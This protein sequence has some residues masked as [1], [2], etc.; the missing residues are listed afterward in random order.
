MSGTRSPQS[1][2]TR[3][4]FL[5]TTG[6]TGMLGVAGAAGM[7]TS[8]GWLAPSQ[9]HAEPEERVARTYHQ[10]HCG[11]H[12]SLACTVRDGRLCLIEPNDAWE[13]KMYATVCLKG[14][15]EVQHVYSN[16]RI[17]TPL[18]L[19]G[20]RGSGDYESISWDE[21]LDLM[22]DTI[23]GIQNKH[24]KDALYISLSAEAWPG[25]GLLPSLFGA[26]L[27]GFEGI[28]IGIGN[29]F[30]P[31]IGGYGTGL[32]YSANDPRDWVNSKTIILMGTNFLESCLVQ[33]TLLFDAKEAG[34]YIVSVDPNFTTTASKSHQWMPIEP[35][36]D[37]ALLL[38]MA[39]AAIENDWLDSDFMAHHTSFPFLVDVETGALL[40]EDTVLEDEAVTGE[41]GEA[42]VQSTFFV[43]DAQT[44]TPQSHD[45]FQ[46]KPAIEGTF[47]IEGRTYTTVF[48]LLKEN[49]KQYTT[50]WASEKTGIPEDDLIELARR[51]AND[52]PASLALGFGGGD[53]YANADVIGHAAAVL[54][55]LT[56]QYGKIGASTGMFGDGGLRFDT[57][58]ALASWEL[59][60]ELA[61]SEDEMSAYDYRYQENNVKAAIFAGDTMQQHFAN[62]QATLDWLDTL[63]FIVAI[64]IYHTTVTSYADLVLPVCTKFESDEEIASVKSCYNHVLLRERVLDPLFESKTDFA[65]QNAIAEKLGYAK[66][67]PSSAEELVRFSIEESDDPK[68]GGLTLEQLKNSGGIVAHTDAEEVYR[69]FLDMVLPTASTRMEVYYEYMLEFGQHLPTYEEPNEAFVENPLAQKYPLMFS[70]PRTRFHIHNQFCDAT[71]L[72]QFY[73]PYVELN[74]LDMEARNI[75]DGDT[76]ETFNDRG[77]IQTTVRS[78]P[79]VRPGTARMFEGM[80]SKYMKAGNMQNLTNDT[81]IERGYRLM[82]GPVIPFNDT[83]VEVKKA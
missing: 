32:M 75:V 18:K 34:A 42:G 37:A 50:Q 8:S 48:S 9:A 12:C 36:T 28:D 39:T 43:W 40:R 58:A 54:T 55:A 10:S 83:L 81:M 49:Q 24:G 47:L 66:Y 16:E 19:I 26:Q 3:R 46:G 82:S 21:A 45:A 23:G 57:A 2:L 35:G 4:S 14:L 13:D 52:G 41:D 61:P 56:G 59:P 67:M 25:L 38:G 78:N 7:L 6:A 65:L 77:S 31:A 80:W 79:S 5:K 74:P 15:S 60:E 53:K 30:E 1:G 20:E 70:Q 33:G 44:K 73:E 64:D 27:G 63:E 29:G 62:M 68:L 51:Y 76:V 11:G 72:Q 22:V 17:Q 69:T 71:W